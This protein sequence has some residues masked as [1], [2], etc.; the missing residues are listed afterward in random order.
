MINDTLKRK[1]YA[2]KIAEEIENHYSFNNKSGHGDNIVFAISGKW[3]EGKTTLLDLLEPRLRERGFTVIRFNP[4]QYSHEDI[5]LKR[6]FLKEIKRMLESDVDLKDLYYDRSETKIE[7]KNIIPFLKG[8]L[9]ASFVIG[10]VV[11]AIFKYPLNIW[12]IDLGNIIKN[13]WSSGIGGV[14]LTLLIIPLLIKT[15]TIGSR[16]AQIT[17]AEEFE[18]KFFELL[19]GKT[20][21]VIFIDDLDRCTPKTVKVILD[22]LRTFF[23]HPECSYVITGDHTVIEKYAAEELGNENIEEGRR[24]LKKLFDVYWR[25]PLPTPKIFEEFLTDEIKKSGITFSETQEK[26]IKNFLLDDRFFERNPRHVKR[27]ITALRFA[28]ESVKAQFEELSQN[29]KAV[30]NDEGTE[31]Q[32]KSIKEIIDNPD[33][34]GKILLIQE[35]LYAVYEKLILYPAEIVSHEK[36]LRGKGSPEELTIDGKTVLKVLGDNREALKIYASIINLEPQFTDINNS[37]I[38]DPTI[39][40]AFSGATGLPSLKGPDEADFPQYLKA[41]QLV[42]RLAQ[43]LHVLPREKKERFAQRALQI[44][45]DKTTTEQEKLNIISES[46]KMALQ[47]DEWALQLKEW[48]DRLFTLATPHQNTLAKDF[49]NAVLQKSPSLLSEIKKEKP[50]YFELLW[51]TLESIEDTKLHSEVKLELETILKG[52]ISE[53]PLNLKGVEVYLNKFSSSVIEE[54]IKSKLV[55]PQTARVYLEHCQSLGYPDGKIAKIVILKLKGFIEEFANIDWVIQNRD[56]LKKVG[57]FNDVKNNLSKWLKDSKQLIKIV[58]IKD[59]LELT[60]Q[61]INIIK[62]EIIDLIHNSADLQFIEDV[63]IQAILD[64]EAKKKVFENLIGILADKDEVLEKRKKAAI[65]LNKTNSLW[66]GMGSNEIYNLLK[67]IK[68][69]K[70]ARIIDLKDSQKTIL[71]S[72]GYNDLNKNENEK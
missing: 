46:L 65:L 64:K 13:F 62:N 48:K 26:N 49:W 22:S 15:I 31:D 34:L 17:T 68:K 66:N 29:S 11:P 69:L 19:K 25:L 8:V 53:Q 30:T 52:F 35:K 41:G 54:E 50:Q 40:L 16:K 44:F 24:F 1:I 57:V 7:W 20:K 4:W 37:T 70:L 61:E 6:A 56:F 33:L 45:D 60:E 32:K 5:S 55:D 10:I 47:L 27:F 23:R 72:W 51:D 9:I 59:I 14:I 63:N 18:N 2:D 36:L 39:F 71:E 28:L 43:N 21:V 42:E 3:G 38:Y 12:W 67:Q 58:S